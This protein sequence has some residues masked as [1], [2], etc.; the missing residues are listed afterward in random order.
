[1]QDYDIFISYSRSDS[2]IINRLA[3]DLK[4]SNI[5]VWL[6]IW[7]ISPGADTLKEINR[8][9]E[10]S[11]QLLVAFSANSLRSNWV[12]TEWMAKFWQQ[13]NEGKILVVPVLIDELTLESIP[14]IIRGKHHVKLYMDYNSE[15]KNLIY[16]IRKG[17]EKKVVRG[18]LDGDFGEAL[19]NDITNNKNKYRSDIVFANYFIKRLRSLDHIS[20]S[21]KIELLLCEVDFAAEEE[22]RECELIENKIKS[23]PSEIVILTSFVRHFA[24][25]RIEKLQKKLH[26]IGSRSTDLDKILKQMIEELNYTMLNIEQ[27]D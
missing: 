12:E 16:H 26:F 21:E 6:D 19:K 3:K 9:L 13:I 10:Q 24:L 2:K 20:T 4:K 7:E 22:K 27:A 17:K 23:D 8:G 11:E 1:M 14:L 18:L 25:E 5:N 15:L